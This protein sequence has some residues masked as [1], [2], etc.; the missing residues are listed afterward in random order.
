MIV[1]VLLGQ[2]AVLDERISRS[3]APCKSLEYGSVTVYYQGD[4]PNDEDIEQAIEDA[5]E[6]TRL[7]RA[8]SIDMQQ[9]PEWRIE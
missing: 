1:H 2:S 3:C 9:I 8:S 5:I 7:D 6:E 4:K